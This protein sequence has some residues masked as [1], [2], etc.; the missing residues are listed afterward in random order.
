M[1]PYYEGSLTKFQIFF[2]SFLKKKKK[3]ILLWAIIG[4]C[5]GVDEVKPPDIIKAQLCD[6]LLLES[7]KYLSIE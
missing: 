3:V 5:G 2:F 6:H 4:S 7:H 1:G